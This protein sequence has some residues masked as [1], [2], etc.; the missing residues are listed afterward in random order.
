MKISRLLA[1]VPY[2]VVQ[3]SADTEVTG[4]ACDTRKIS[5]GEVFVCITG[6]VSDG[7]GFIPHFMPGWREAAEL[8]VKAIENASL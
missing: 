7:H 4:V 8:I 2:T 5:G 3:G 6:T 1:E